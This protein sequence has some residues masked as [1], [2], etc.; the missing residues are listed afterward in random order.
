M[1]S[2]DAEA[3]H[4]LKEAYEDVIVKGEKI[5][6]VWFR[7]PFLENVQVN[8]AIVLNFEAKRRFDR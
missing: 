1:D 8:R 6:G 5:W 2:L 7:A 3:W 4:C